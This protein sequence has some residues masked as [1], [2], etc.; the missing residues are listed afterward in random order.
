M[1]TAR[2]TAPATWRVPGSRDVGILW[3]G[4]GSRLLIGFLWTPGATPAPIDHPAADGAYAT[5]AQADAAVRAFL[6][7]G[8]PAG[9]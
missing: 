8:A 6:A 2:S 5:F 7:A 3:L 1:P 9:R 4:A